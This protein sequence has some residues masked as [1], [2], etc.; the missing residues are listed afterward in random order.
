MSDQKLNLSIPYPGLRPF[1]EPD[2]V[3]FF[4]RDQQANELLMRL[5][6]SAFVAVVGSSGS[7]K[8]SLVRAGLLPLLRQGFLFGTEYSRIA[9]ARPG[10][11]PYQ[12]LACE[13]SKLNRSLPFDEILS[14]LRSSDDGLLRVVDWL[15]AAGAPH[16]LIVIDQFEELFGFRRSGATEHRSQSYASRDESA[17]FVAML[18]TSMR[19]ADEHLRVIITMRSDFVGDCEVF[20]GLPQAVSQSQF[21]VPRLT[22]SQ[23]EEAITGPSRIRHRDAKF[24]AFDFEPGLVN[25]LINEAGD[26]P[27][28]LPLLQHALMRTWKLSQ[29]AIT[30]P[31]DEPSSQTFHLPTNITTGSNS[32]V[33][34]TSRGAMTATLVEPTHHSSIASSISA[35]S[36]RRRLTFDDYTKAGRIEK[37]LSN[38]A[39][40]ALNSLGEAEQRIARHMFLLLCDTSAEGQITRRRPLVQEVMEVAQASCEQIEKIVRA[41]QSDD[42]NFLLPPLSEPTTANSPLA[43]LGLLGTGR[44]AGGEGQPQHGLQS[45]TPTTVLDISNE[46]LL[47]QWRIL[48]TW[49]EDEAKSV[50]RYRELR[51]IVRRVRATQKAEFLS[52]AHLELAQNWQTQSQPSVRWA[53]RYDDRTSSATDDLP[54]CLK[55]ISDSRQ[56]IEDQKREALAATERLR[57][58]RKAALIATVVAAICLLISLNSLWDAKRATARAVES[59]GKAKQKES[60]AKTQ[61]AEADKAAQLAAESAVEALEQS[62]VALKAQAAAK[63]SEHLSNV[64]LYANQIVNADRE[65]EKPGF[66]L[67]RQRLDETRWDLRGWEYGY[68]DRR[69][70]PPHHTLK[71]HS[72]WVMSVSFS[73]DVKRIVSGSH[74]NTVKVWDAATGQET[75]ALKGHSN[76]VSSV[77]F[78]PDGKL[79]VSGSSDKTVKVWDA[80]TGQETLTLKGHSGYVYSVSF[81]PDGQR[82]VSGSLDNT[83]KVWDAATGQ[84]TL[85]LKGHSG[86]VSSV[87]F[88]PDG[89]RIVSGSADNTV[90]VW[91]AATGQ[92]TL[93]LKGH[94]DPVNSVSFSPDGQRIVSGSDDNT[95]KVWDAATGQETLTTARS[96]ALPEYAS[97]RGSASSP[98]DRTATAKT[99]REPSVK[100]GSRA[101]ARVSAVGSTSQD[102]G[103]A[104]S[105]AFSPDGQ[106]LAAGNVNGLIS[107]W[108]ARTGEVVRTLQGHKGAVRRVAFSLDG[109]WIASASE[110]K[111]AK[112][113]DAQT[114][115]LQR[116]FEGHTDLVSGIAFHPHSQQ[117]LTTSKDKTMKLWDVST[118]KLIRTY[119]GHSVLVNQ[120]VFSRDGKHIA[121]SS[122]DMTVRIWDTEKDQSLRTLTG[123]TGFVNEVAFSPD[124]QRVA[125]ASDDKTIKLW[126]VHTGECLQ[127]LTD[128]VSNVRS[129]QF[130]PD[131]RH[132]VSGSWDH[133]WKLRDAQTGEPVY[134]LNGHSDAVDGVCFS[135]DGS[136]IAS[137]GM[138]RRVR[139]WD[140]GGLVGLP[141]ASEDSPTLPTAASTS[142]PAPE[143]IE[144][145]PAKEAFVVK[146]VEAPTILDSPLPAF[147]AALWSLAAYVLVLAITALSR[148]RE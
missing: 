144:K 133:T 17:A 8:S 59:E 3:L 135:P 141:T 47:R 119:E 92:E 11:D 38:D 77:S 45:L 84:E 67:A 52:E 126:N 43:P 68:L 4:G 27:D 23:M 148:R 142:P 51:A 14:L 39:T 147:R 128:H 34:G 60:E 94:S 125:S 134:A 98:P 15:R 130:S 124:G 62:A 132:L 22:R 88:S 48:Q 145:S 90:K 41:F 37:A 46:S 65:C 140:I 143:P 35:E 112:L 42:R 96:Q 81:S 54:A 123:H 118:G 6:D 114:G 106:Q 82:I 108:N 104:F 73:P 100:T 29:V 105:V 58:Q 32:N 93:T 115:V 139:L 13:L 7:G 70:S 74:D 76:G 91:D 80:T 36:N 57:K 9:V 89:Q 50:E 1:D 85:T 75:L 30:A 79:I 86:Y 56:H 107:V 26:R 111:T 53:Q 87:S 64:R 40:T 2:H 103:A 24:A 55:L 146:A 28:Q 138:D 109:K 49:M 18:L 117:V 10:N 116:T 120:A 101:W 99:S 63:K 12:N 78:S 33:E 16:V 69:V 95:M 44:G 137:V 5:E 129:V 122:D 31:R 83:V 127:T 72:N 25:T 66:G 71:G 131:G 61:K 97:P 20:L 113:W 136:R 121:S 110:D 21:L 102:S 19:K